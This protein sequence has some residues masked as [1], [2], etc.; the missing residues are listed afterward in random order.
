MTSPAPSNPAPARPAALNSAGLAK[1]DYK[2][3]PST[4]CPGCGH[5]S[6]SSRIIDAAYALGLRPHMVLKLSGI[7]CSSKS[8]AYFL[9]GSHGINTVHGRM[10][11]VTTGA[12]LAQRGHTA[13]AVSGDGDTGSIGIGQFKHAVRRNVPM[14][15]IIENNGVY[16]L[17]KGQFSATADQG[18]TLKYIGTND[19]PA[20]D[21][22]AEAILAGA[23]FVAR[24]FAGDA[25][26]VTEL[27]KAA[28]S[29]KGIAVLD[30]ISP[31]VTFNNHDESTKSYGYGKAHEVP[32]HDITFVPEFDEIRVDYEPGEVLSVRLHDGP[33]VQLRKLGRDYDPRSRLSAL[34]LL[35]GA[36]HGGEL[37]T[38][39]LYLDETRPT[40]L[41][42]QHVHD[43][44]LA[45]LPEAL[46]RPSPQSLADV[47]RQFG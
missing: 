25:K 1:N 18:Q 38:G 23:G 40:L 39:L 2:G 32:I 27:L 30:I 45:L 13:I 5:D 34:A 47:M 20:L 41:D 16:G 15:Y 28:L 35:E 31:C 10:P 21:L 43:T 14:V 11:S 3:L 37:L 29:Y 9:N 36:R 44:P 6:I 22:C 12:L 17:T 42:T 33:T 8:P 26:Q 19:L 46:T 7:G 24:S 4:L